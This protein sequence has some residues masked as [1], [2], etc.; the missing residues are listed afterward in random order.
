[1]LSC[2]LKSRADGRVGAGFDIPTT[3]VVLSEPTKPVWLRVL[4]LDEVRWWRR[5]VDEGI[6]NP[7]PDSRGF[8]SETCGCSAFAAA[9]FEV[10]DVLDTTDAF[11]A[12]RSSDSSLVR[13]LT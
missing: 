13:R 7:D 12:A 10:E 11:C 5:P 6:E 4:V 8:G 3:D 9:L 1:M 2:R